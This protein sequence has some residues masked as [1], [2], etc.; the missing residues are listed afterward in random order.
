M[1]PAG[2]RM[3]ILGVDP[4]LRVTG[5]GLIE[6]RDNA[7]FYVASGCLRTADGELPAR[8]GEIF[9]GLGEVISRWQPEQV[10]IEK[11]FVN[12]NPQ[13]TLALGQARGAAI[14]AAVSQGLSVAEYTALQIKQAVVGQGHADKRQVQ[15]MI[16]RLLGLDA[17]PATDAADALACAL[18]HAHGT[19]GSA[20]WL[21]GGRRVRHGRV[22]S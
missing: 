11:V 7:P 5:F 1:V 4:G 12:V 6:W 2:E 10:A 14:C 21:W 8:L 9:A 18:C 17:A 20:A 3:R 22:L 16:V 19:Q 15:D 13:S